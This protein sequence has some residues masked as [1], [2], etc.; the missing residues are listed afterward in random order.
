MRGWG[1]IAGGALRLEVLV[2]L[3]RVYCWYL[4][5]NVRSLGSFFLFETNN[6]KA[7]GEKNAVLKF[8]QDDMKILMP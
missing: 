8:I 3:S 1:A 6:P 2:L 7:I 5:L 4:L